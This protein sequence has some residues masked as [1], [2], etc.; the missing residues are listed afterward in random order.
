MLPSARALLTGILDYAGLFPP[1]QLP[2]PEAVR[3]Y[4]RHRAGGEGWLLARFVAP[5]SRLAELSPL[6]AG[7]SDREPPV[8]LAVL[9]RPSE[10]DGDIADILSFTDRHGECA[11]VEQLELR[12]PD[13]PGLIAGTVEQSLA[14]LRE[15]LPAAT[16]FFEPSLLDRWPDRLS[17]AADAVGAAAADGATLGLKVRCG[18]LDAAAV[19]S[20]HAVAAALA[21]CRRAGI[22]LKATQGLHQPLRHFDRALGTTVHG[23]L[24]L[25]V[26]GVLGHLHALSE[27]ELLA[28]VEESE[29]A[30]FRLDDNGLAWRELAAGLEGIAAARRAAVTSFGSCSFSEPRDALRELG[31]LDRG[32]PSAS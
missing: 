8:R 24:N 1:A 7:S 5:A 2:M 19:P 14:A 25:F 27:Q 3:R 6:L 9:A 23:F 21:T 12:L 22:P 30:A 15:R 10:L 29:A 17:R 20:P 11:T 18:G 16:P 31:L 13:E 32:G 26:A 4:Q 28:I